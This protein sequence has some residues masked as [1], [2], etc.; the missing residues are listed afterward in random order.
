M[1]ILSI[2][3]TILVRALSD[4]VSTILPSMRVSF[5]P[6]GGTESNPMADLAAAPCALAERGILTLCAAGVA[7]VFWG[8]VT[9]GLVPKGA[10]AVI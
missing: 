1:A 9:A 2:M 8:I 7:A 4:A 3:A 6:C 5:R 10:S